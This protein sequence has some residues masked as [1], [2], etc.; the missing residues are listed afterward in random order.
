MWKKWMNYH[1][2]LPSF[3]KILMYVKLFKVCEMVYVFTW[4]WNN[5][6]FVFLPLSYWFCGFICSTLFFFP[7]S[8]WMMVSC[9][10]AIAT[11]VITNEMSNCTGKENGAAQKHLPFH[12]FQWYRKFGQHVCNMRAFNDSQ[13]C[14]SCTCLNGF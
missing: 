8:N 5:A 1:S 9:N 2:P 3:E 7:F 14:F 11:N 4:A 6:P 10:R 12:K 13:I